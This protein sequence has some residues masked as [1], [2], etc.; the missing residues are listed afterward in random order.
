MATRLYLQG[1]EWDGLQ[2]ISKEWVARA[3]SKQIDTADR[4]DNPDWRQGY[5]FQF[6]MSRHGYRGDGAYGQ[7]CEVL[8]E[9]DAVV[10]QPLRE[11]NLAFASAERFQ[12]VVLAEP[13]LRDD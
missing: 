1:G 7:F 3:T 8:P 6:W 2:L 10:G 12:A 11:R 5:G 4:R 13:D 9:Q